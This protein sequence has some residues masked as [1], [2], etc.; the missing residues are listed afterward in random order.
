MKRTYRNVAVAGA[1]V[2][3]EYRSGNTWVRFEA[4]RD[5]LFIHDVIDSKPLAL[6]EVWALQ[7]G[8]GESGCT[9]PQGYDWSGIRDSSPGARRA[10]FLAAK[11]HLD[12]DKWMERMRQGGA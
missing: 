6:S 3:G 5:L 12:F 10:M 4:D 8:Y 9:P 11:Q 7:D 2:T 1:L